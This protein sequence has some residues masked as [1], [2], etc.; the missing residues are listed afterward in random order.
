[1]NGT[2]YCLLAADVSLPHVF[3]A[4]TIVSCRN[5]AMSFTHRSGYGRDPPPFAE[6]ILEK[7]KHAFLG[8]PSVCTDEAMTN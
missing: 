8:L 4:T 1:M 6:N 5:P 2:P 7:M 3:Y